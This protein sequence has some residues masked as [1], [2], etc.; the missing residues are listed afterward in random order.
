MS[1]SERARTGLREMPSNAAWL[2]SQA[3]KPAENVGDAAQSAAIGARDRGRRASAALIDA[4]PVGGDSVDIRMRRAREAAERARDAEQQAVEASEEA[5]DRAE[6]ARKV[7]ERGSARRAEV[8]RET[9]RRGRQD[10]PPHPGG[11]RRHRGR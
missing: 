5:R 9:E 3:L 10:T 8:Q 2:I 6:H 7:G 4:A 1:L 11:G